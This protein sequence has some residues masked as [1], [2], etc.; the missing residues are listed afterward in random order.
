ML[1]NQ[2]LLPSKYGKFGPIV[3]KDN[4]HIGWNAI[5]MPGVTIGNNCVIG[6]GAVVTHDIPDNSIAVGVPAKV[7]KSTDEYLHDILADSN[8]FEVDEM[9]KK[10]KL[11][12]KYRGCFS[13]KMC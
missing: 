10:E 2:G 4:V 8:S 3:V 6:C 12:S 1:R 11:L 5:I 9:D 7:I 13:E